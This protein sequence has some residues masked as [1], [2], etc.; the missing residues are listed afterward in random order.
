MRAAHPLEGGE[1]RRARAVPGALEFGR[2]QLEALA[3]NVCDQRLAVAVMPVRCG[4]ADAR[5]ARGLREGE[6]GEPALGDEIERRPDQRLAQMTVMVAAAARVSTSSC[7][8]ILH[9]TRLG[10]RGC[11]RWWQECRPVG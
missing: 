6:A 11:S 2:K 3:R 5:R 8:T 7:E 1:R 9:E 4:R 10:R